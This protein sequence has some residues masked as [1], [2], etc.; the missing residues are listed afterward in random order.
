[1]EDVHRDII[2][3]GDTVKTK[4][5]SGGILSPAKPEIGI[6]EA[7]K[8]S[9]DRDTLQIKYK[10]EGKLFDSFI[11]LDGKINEIIKQ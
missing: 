2:K 4:Q 8:D 10:K 5:P 3:I 1:M 6:V 7:T 11:L 9:F